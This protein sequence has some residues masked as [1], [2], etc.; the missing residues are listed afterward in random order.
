MHNIKLSISDFGYKLVDKTYGQDKTE[1]QPIVYDFKYA[2]VVRENNVG[3][4]F[5]E[6][7][8][9]DIDW[10]M[11]DCICYKQLFMVDKNPQ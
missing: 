10:P 7:E 6:T 4:I 2:T 9:I 3:P 11:T 5:I 1:N 8:T